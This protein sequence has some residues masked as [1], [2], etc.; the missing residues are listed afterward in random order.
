MSKSQQVTDWNADVLT[1]AQMKYASTDA[2]VSYEI[3]RKLNSA[4]QK[5][6]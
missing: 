3:Y 2:W 6:F 4:Q 1:E 5:A